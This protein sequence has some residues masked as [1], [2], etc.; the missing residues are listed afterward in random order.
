M[1]W[2]PARMYIPVNQFTG[3]SSSALSAGAGSEAFAAGAFIIGAG[4]GTPIM[5]EISTFGILGLLMNTAAD[6]I[7]HHMAL[8]SDYDR[9]HPMYVR[10]HWTSGSATAADT[11]DWIVRYLKIV[12]NTTIIASPT[13]VL[14]STIAQDTVIGVGYEW[15]T[16]AWGA[17][18]PAVTAVADT[19]EAI[20]WEVELD[21]F[22]AG[23]AEDKFLLGL[24]IMYT[25]KRLYGQSGML[26]EAKPKTQALGD[27]SAN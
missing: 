10:V 25:P 27:V 20:V 13:T 9:R 1:V 6:E 8:P 19:V 23:L 11:V 5:K 2:A 22:A 18:Q 16:T 12:P 14:D 17:I 3:L 7:N 24:E 15:Q 4:V 21:A 26:H